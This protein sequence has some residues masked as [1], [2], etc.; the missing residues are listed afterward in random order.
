MVGTSVL[1]AGLAWAGF[2][3]VSF[4]V[5]VPEKALG[6]D[7]GQ[8]LRYSLQAAE[9][10]GASAAPLYVSDR[11]EE[12]GVFGY[13]LP[14]RPQK[15]FD[16]RYTVVLPPGPASYVADASLAFAYG[17]LTK[18]AGPPARSVTTP[19]GHVAYG[20]FT[21][22]GALT[23]EAGFEPLD[24]DVGHSLRLLG[25]RMDEQ[26][27]EQPSIVRLE[28]QVPT[29]TVRSRTTCASSATWWT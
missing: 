10:A 1:V 22:P 20:L 19:S 28:W 21:P 12:A 16:G 9:L 23:P 14:G 2:D 4:Q 13:L 11:D 5:A 15:R 29:R 26:R 8:P 25:Y 27:A 24:V 18:D 17:V 6:A 3:Y 7:Y